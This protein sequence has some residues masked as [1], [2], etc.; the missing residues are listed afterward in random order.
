MTDK[1]KLIVALRRFYKNK[2][3]FILLESQMKN[4]PSS[5]KT[6]VAAGTIASIRAYGNKIHVTEK[7]KESVFIKNPWEALIEF[8]MKYKEWSFGVLGYDLKNYLE[9]LSSES[10]SLIKTPDLFFFVPEVLLEIDS[11]NSLKVLKG[12]VLEDIPRTVMQSDITIENTHQISKE[13]YIAKII[14]AQ[15]QIREG[16]FYE[17]NLSHPLEFKFSGEGWDLYQKMKSIGPV[18]FGSYIRTNDFEVCSAS[19]E[20]FLSKKGRKLC[21]QPIKGTVSRSFEDDNANIVALS[22]SEKERAENLMIVDLVR[23]DLSRIAEKGSVTVSNL[24]EIQT[25]ET[26]HQMVSTVE[27]ESRQDVHAVEILKAC[28]PMGSMTG[29]P[30]VAAMRAIE[31]LED[32]KRGIYS[33]A[34]G[35]FTPEDDFD[36]SVVIRTAIING[37]R[38]IYPV[39]GAIT[40]DSIPELEWEE[41]LVKAR[42]ITKLMN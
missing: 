9:R 33:G 21:S 31:E 38:L 25:F 12:I 32:Y 24:F 3:D 40:S 7:G 14:E 27:A 29:A 18:P 22:N 37:E 30:K 28:F 39:G 34:I 6:F 11:N 10:K 17:I 4:H 41:T 2:K 26:V 13:K 1:D 36:F 15:Q 23:N 19:P 8:R 16:E 35:Y 42:A 20:R 5:N